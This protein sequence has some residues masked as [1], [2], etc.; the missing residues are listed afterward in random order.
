MSQMNSTH[1]LPAKNDSLSDAYVYLMNVLF[2]QIIRAEPELLS[3]ISASNKDPA[4]RLRVSNGTFYFTLP[5][6]FELVCHQLAR[7]SGPE[8]EQNRSNYL[9]FRKLVYSSPTNYTLGKVGLRIDIDSSHPDH[10]QR[11]Y[12]LFHCANT[13]AN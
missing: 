3:E 8:I 4:S 2:P 6:L 13:A 9:R 7:S 1:R 12:K 10:D 5:D 11:V